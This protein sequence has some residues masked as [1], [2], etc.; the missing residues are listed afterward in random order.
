[1]LYCLT[2]DSCHIDWINLNVSPMYK[3][4]FEC[5]LPSQGKT[6]R[7]VLSTVLALF[8]P[9]MVIGIFCTYWLY[10]TVKLGKPWKQFVKRSILSFVSLLYV[11]CYSL[12]NMS[13]STFY[14]VKVFDGVLL[15]GKD[16]F[17]S[18]WGVD[19]SVRCGDGNHNILRYWIGLPVSLFIGVCGSVVCFVLIV[20]RERGALHLEWIHETLHVLFIGFRPGKEEWDFYSQMRKIS[21]AG[22]APYVYIV[23]SLWQGVVMTLILAFFTVWHLRHRPYR[24][25]LGN[26]N[27]LEGT[28]L[29]VCTVTAGISTILASQRVSS[30]V[31]KAALVAIV[32][33]INAA[34]VTAYGYHLVISKFVETKYTLLLKGVVNEDDKII[35]VL[36]KSWK[37][38]LKGIQKLLGAVA[39]I[40]YSSFDRSRS[41]IAGSS[42]SSLLPSSND[43]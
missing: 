24:T 42:S 8:V 10:D 13:V 20:A 6:P 23:G 21:V 38:N 30:A 25:D 35:V 37:E 41:E 26:L 29:F 15:N 34:S 31:I 2:N 5:L 14:C 3:F 40:I 4:S 36:L 9:F 43:I 16:S 32:F 39:T 12:A 28:S 11:C 27:S 18:Y 22:G 1:M 7:S 17:D 19:T 33:V